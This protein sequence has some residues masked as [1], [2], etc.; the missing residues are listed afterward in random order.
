VNESIGD[1]IN[2]WQDTIYPRQNRPFRLEVY[3]NENA[4]WLSD[5]RQD[6]AK[7]KMSR[8]RMEA[9]IEMKRIMPEY[10]SVRSRISKLTN[11]MK[12]PV[13]R[14]VVGNSKSNCM[15]KTD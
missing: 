10:D 12:Q 14:S 15:S 6:D 11:E 1:L 4:I 5:S 9:D 7:V 13:I 2:R 8:N 3:Q